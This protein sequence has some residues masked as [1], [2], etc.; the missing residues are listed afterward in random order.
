MSR[1]ELRNPEKAYNKMTVE[2]LDILWPDV[3][4]YCFTS[5]Y[6]TLS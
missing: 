5:S 2:E 6:V 4:E 3:R 1:T